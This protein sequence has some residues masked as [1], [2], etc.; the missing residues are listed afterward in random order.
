MFLAN[1]IC[2]PLVLQ[3]VQDER[4]GWAGYNQDRAAYAG[5]WVKCIRLPCVVAVSK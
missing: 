3:Q 1:G 5:S 2:Y 4:V